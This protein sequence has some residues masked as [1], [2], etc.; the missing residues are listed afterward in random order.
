M[1]DKIFKLKKKRNVI[2]SFRVVRLRSKFNLTFFLIYRA[3]SGKHFLIK[4]I[5]H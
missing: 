5:K 4:V 3:R 2:L 1:T